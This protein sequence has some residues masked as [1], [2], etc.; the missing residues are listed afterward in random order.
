M[1][2]MI[3]PLTTTPDAVVYDLTREDPSRC[4]SLSGFYLESVQGEGNWRNLDFT[5]GG[6]GGE[7][8]G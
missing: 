8:V 1:R 5:V 7:H 2:S 6:G 4:S 3:P